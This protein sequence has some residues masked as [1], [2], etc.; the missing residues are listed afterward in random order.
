MKV[1][2]WKDVFR[3]SFMQQVKTK[4]FIISTIVIALIAAT[5]AFLADFLPTL[6]LEDELN[7]AERA[8]AGENILTVE[9]IYVSNETGYEFDLGKVASDNKVT[10]KDVTPEEADAKIKEIADTTERAVVAKITA[11]DSGFAVNSRYAAGQSGVDKYDSEMLNSA[12][13]DA[14]R[15]QVLL[16]LG[17][18]E[19]SIGLAKA[20]VAVSCS[21]AGQEPVSFVQQ[22]LNTVVPMLSSIILF[23]FIF[24]Y[25]SMVAQS[26]AIEKASRVIEYLLTSIKPLAIIL[27]KVLAMCCVS[28]LQFLLIGLG[29]TIGFLV[30]LPF[31]IVTKIG[32]MLGAAAQQIQPAAEGAGSGAV[33]NTAEIVGG[34]TEAFSG[35]DASAFIV[36]LVTFILGFLFYAGI[37]GLAGA[38]VSKMEDLSSAIQPLSLIGVLGFYLAYFPQVT[39]EENTM[40]LVARYIPISSP[41]VLPSDYLLGRIDFAGAL[42]AI[43][44]LAVADI[45]IMMFVAKVYESLILH[46]GNRL[47]LGDIIKMSK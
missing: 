10:I 18:P 39:G 2:G 29:G 14:V 24:S 11:G 5:M 13:A 40:S 37:A 25:S 6:L 42:I 21:S 20:E 7:K 16:K 28:I 30:S 36:M 33:E 12:L 41:F 1:K 38:S 15:D 31:G 45:L 22:M 44:V 9:T 32:P 27:G 4:S 23:M 3:F 47:K 35:V 19:D 26:V 34:I 8:A 17:V 43:A 46:T